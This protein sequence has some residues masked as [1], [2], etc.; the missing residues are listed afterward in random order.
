MHTNEQARTPEG[1]TPARSTAR[2]RAPE[3]GGVPA[4]LLALQR[5][6]GNSAVVQLLDQAG[7]P[8][9]QE[10][11]EHGAGCGHRSTEPP[12]V[13]RKSVVSGLSL[14]KSGRHPFASDLQ[15][16][17]GLTPLQARC[18]TIS[19]E[20]ISEAVI[21]AVN[22]CLAAGNS[23]N[24]GYLHGTV[25][26]VFPAGGSLPATHQNLPNSAALQAICTREFT[27]AVNAVN[28]LD[29]MLAIPPTVLSLGPTNAQANELIQA[30]NNSPGNLRPAASNTNSSIQGALDLTP[31]AGGPQLL[32]RGSS[33]VDQNQT[34][35]EYGYQ[36]TR[37]TADRNV[38]RVAPTHEEQVWNLITRTAVPEVHLFSSGTQLQSSDYPNMNTGTM[39]N[40]N[41]TP[42]AIQVPGSNPP[43]YFLF[44]L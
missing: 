23:A 40:A 37:L 15:Q 14:T 3:S 20:T 19:Y 18:H 17:M 36:Q 34:Y 2:T 13:Q 5:T 12:V 39:T 26:S 24:L 9:T 8:Q 44:D 31:L 38:L 7:R 33:I 1:D 42:V 43:V 27:R 35:D 4:G 16:A 30:L 10:R 32:R 41:P 21:T 6:A 29:A 25:D 22:M 28:S 11:H